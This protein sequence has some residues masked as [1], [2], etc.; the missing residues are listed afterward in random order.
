[1]C[2]RAALLGAQLSC[3]DLG[4]ISPLQGLFSLSSDILSTVR[5]RRDSYVGC[6]HQKLMVVGKQLLGSAVSQ[7]QLFTSTNYPGQLGKLRYL[8]IGP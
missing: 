6:S 4:P 5:G 2:E 7:N 3:G 8:V 1:M